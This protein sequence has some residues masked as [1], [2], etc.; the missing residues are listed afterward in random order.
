[1]TDKEK[2]DFHQEAALRLASELPIEA[3]LDIA[4]LI[5]EHQETSRI[6]PEA[7]RAELETLL[8]ELRASVVELRAIR[9]RINSLGPRVPPGLALPLA[10]FYAL[11]TEFFND[12]SK[13]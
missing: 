6:C 11:I 1:M 10:V 7:E 2:I 3:L 9:V 13:K 8:R 12:P 5:L 4:Q